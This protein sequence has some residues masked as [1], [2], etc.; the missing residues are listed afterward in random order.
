MRRTARRANGNTE[1]GTHNGPEGSAAAS[2]PADSPDASP[3]ASPAAPPAASP[4]A[5]P[6]RPRP[7]PPRRPPLR[8]RPRPRPRPPSRTPSSSRCGEE[9]F[10]G[11][12]A[13]AAASGAHARP[14]ASAPAQW[15]VTDDA[16]SCLLLLDAPMDGIA[17]ALILQGPQIHA[18][19][20]S[21]CLP[22][23]LRSRPLSS[24]VEWEGSLLRTRL[25]SKAT[26]CA[27]E[28]VCVP[29]APNH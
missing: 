25:R 26:A 16:A 7:T 22:L 3:T 9:E 14:V 17:P 20:P 13:S 4:V 5:D 19:P 6:P 28:P 18:G 29:S 11:T 12:R 2:S 24:F 27:F 21:W 23:A 8:P 10:E 1:V 15:I